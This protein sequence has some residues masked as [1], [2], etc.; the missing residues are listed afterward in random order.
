MRIAYFDQ[1]RRGFVVHRY[2]VPGLKS[3]FSVWFSADGY[4][5]DAERI[6]AR[7]RTFPVTVTS[8]AWCYIER[9][10]LAGLESASAIQ[11]AAANGEYR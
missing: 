5:V 4:A 8:P 3:H 2:R 7:G 9:Y 1:G 10:Q 6:D 11:A